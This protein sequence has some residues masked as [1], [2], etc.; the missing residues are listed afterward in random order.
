MFLT[1]ILDLNSQGSTLVGDG[2]LWSVE[3]SSQR[4][5]CLHSPLIKWNFL[6]TMSLRI[7]SYDQQTPLWLIHYLRIGN[8]WEINL[9]G[10]VTSYVQPDEPWIITKCKNQVTR[11]VSSVSKSMAEPP[12]TVAK[13]ISDSPMAMIDMIEKHDFKLFLL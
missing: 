13:G 12:K 6:G 2:K 1:L 5:S 3:L 9:L 8:S 7:T 10:S 4:E 11:S